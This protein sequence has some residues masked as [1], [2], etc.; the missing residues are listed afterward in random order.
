MD[1]DLDGEVGG[2]GA[3]DGLD[4]EG[5]G[6]VGD[7][8]GVE[9]KGEGRA[10]DAAEELAVERELGAGQVAGSGRLELYA[11]GQGLAG[12]GGEESEGVVDVEHLIGGGLEHGIGAQDDGGVAGSG[13]GERAGAGGGGEVHV[14]ATRFEAE[15]ADALPPIG[16]VGFDG[17]DVLVVNG[18][19]DVLPASA[20]EYPDGVDA[21]GEVGMGGVD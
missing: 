12:D 10:G 7:A 20:G 14:M 18:Q 17:P 9:G 8:C 6:A 21:S 19:G 3:I 5:V 15:A 11:A 4:A 1:G 2:A 13:A 16:E